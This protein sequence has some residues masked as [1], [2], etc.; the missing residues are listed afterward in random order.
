M[1]EK[2]LEIMAMIALILACIGLIIACVGL[3]TVK[4]EATPPHYADAASNAQEPIIE[5]PWY[6][7]TH[8]IE[9]QLRASDELTEDELEELIRV[10]YLEAGAESDYCI[11]C[12]T[13]VAFNQLHSGL[14]GSTMTEVLHRPGNYDETIYRIWTIEPTQ[15]VRDIVMDVY[16]NGVSLP[17]RIMF[18]RNNYYHDLSWAIPEFNTDNVFFSSSRWCQ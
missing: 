10:V 14:F 5:V 1:F 9:T 17:A 16:L 6:Y 3:L 15:R 2:I 13:D 8:T 12:V 11:R 18:Y 4:T 7:Y